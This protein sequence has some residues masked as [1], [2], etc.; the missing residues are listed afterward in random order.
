MNNELTEE[1]LEGI[2]SQARSQQM[3]GQDSPSLVMNDTL[4]GCISPRTLV[5]P[6]EKVFVAPEEMAH[7][8]VHSIHVSYLDQT[9]PKSGPPAL[10]ETI[11]QQEQVINFI[12][13]III[14]KFFCLEH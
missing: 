9:V 4:G 8:T 12:I 6:G 14:I 3:Q 10:D 5:S 1:F 13:N 2:A 11:P 7:G